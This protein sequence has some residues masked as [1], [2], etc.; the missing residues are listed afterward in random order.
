MV[1]LIWAMG[2]R[3]LAQFGR[4]IE[5]PDC[6]SCK[7]ARLRRAPTYRNSRDPTSSS[8]T[9]TA[10]S[11]FP[12][13]STTRL[14]FSVPTF[15]SYVV[16]S[17]GRATAETCPMLSPARASLHV[18]NTPNNSTVTPSRS[19]QTRSQPRILGQD[20]RQLPPPS[21]KPELRSDRGRGNRSSFFVSPPLS[22]TSLPSP[23]PR[24][25]RG[26]RRNSVRGR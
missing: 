11:G 12:S 17:R 1:H 13:P 2:P 8:P 15:S 18:I 16:L 5:P 22:P 10:A 20:P 26:W 25:S 4:V 7:V 6:P 9:S 24:W 19:P 3:S 23:N 21:R 14:F